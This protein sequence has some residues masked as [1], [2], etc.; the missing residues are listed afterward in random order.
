MTYVAAAECPSSRCETTSFGVVR[1]VLV[2]GIRQ[3]H[4]GEEYQ[5]PDV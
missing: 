4:A 2:P 1:W 5:T 3:S